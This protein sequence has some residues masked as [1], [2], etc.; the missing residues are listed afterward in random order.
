MY[1]VATVHA[2]VLKT[3]GT[4]KKWIFRQAMRGVV[5]DSVLDGKKTGFDVPYEF[6]IRGPLSEYVRSVL[7]DPAI[8]AWGIL[9]SG[10]LETQIDQTVAQTRDYACRLYRLLN[11][12]I[13]HMFYMC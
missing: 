1:L 8:K 3:N 13:W 5:P 2:M 4:Q 12:A 10:C 9:D 7:L 11:L 6:W